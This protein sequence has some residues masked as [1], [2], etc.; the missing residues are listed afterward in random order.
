MM[1]EDDKPIDFSVLTQEDLVAC[2]MLCRDKK[3]Q[4][5]TKDKQISTMMDAIKREVL[6]RMNQ[7]GETGFR[8]VA[9]NVSRVLSNKVSCASEGW[10]AFYRWLYE[11]M[12]NLEATGQDPAQAFAFLHKRIS[13]EPVES[14]MA[15]HAGEVPPSINVSPEYTLMVSKPRK[16]VIA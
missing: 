5:A 7:T 9:G 14:Y 16:P 1:E 15:A 8:T 12:K 4:L 6:Q 2:Y 11:H 13:V 10:P 3:E